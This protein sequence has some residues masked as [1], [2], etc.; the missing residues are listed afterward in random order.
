MNLVTVAS[1]LRGMPA[2]D[3]ALPAFVGPG[4]GAESDK[5]RKRER[6]SGK[7]YRLSGIILNEVGGI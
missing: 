7:L 3:L 1:A 4:G 5:R 6:H 2:V